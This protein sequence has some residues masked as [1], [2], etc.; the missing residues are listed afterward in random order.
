MPLTREERLV[1]EEIIKRI[2]SLE[3]RATASEQNIRTL[4]EFV[5]L[6]DDVGNILN[7]TDEELIRFL[8]ASMRKLIG[9]D[10]IVSL[11]DHKDDL[12]GGDCFAKL[13][14]NLIS[15]EDTEEEV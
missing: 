6:S 14:A 5:K 1:L 3:K 15:E 2:A 12:S 11:H 10:S 7:F 4:N 13:G 9:S 8:G